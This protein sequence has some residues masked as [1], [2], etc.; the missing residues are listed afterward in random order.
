MKLAIMQPYLFPYL[1]YFQL[2][3][4][5]DKFVFYDD[6]N[7]IKN[8]WIN[9]NRLCVGGTAHYVTFPLA[10]ASPFQKINEI[11]IQN[12]KVWRKKLAERIRH[13][14]SKAPYFA[15]VN[16]LVLKI[17]MAEERSMANAAKNS[18]TEVC[19]YLSLDTEFVMTSSIYNNANL[20]GVD[21]VIDICRREF[22][23]EY[24]NPPGGRELYDEALFKAAG[25]ELHFIDPRLDAYPQFS[26]KFIPGL[27]IIDVLMFNDPAAVRKMFVA[28][29]AQ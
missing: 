3:A 27:S 23:D 2:I 16:A 1:G 14:Y 6:V 28:E 20:S 7:F 4:Q 10:G 12:D 21:R 11:L 18:I 22:A 13:S 5:V 17:L 8:G 26:A 29:V 19:D 15:A 24:Y 25:M 9:R